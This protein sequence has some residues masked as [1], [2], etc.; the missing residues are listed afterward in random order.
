VSGAGV[1]GRALGSRYTL[2]ERIGQGA[3]GEVWRAWDR[4][5]ERE[6][7]AKLLWPQHAADPEILGR[8]VHERSV[9][10]GLD[11]P[12]VV[13]VHDFVVEGQDLAIVMD[14]VGGPSVGT[15]LRRQGTLPA[16]SAVP[17]AVA[18]LGALDSAH[19]RGVVHRD[20]KPDNVLLAHPGTPRAQDVRLADFGIAG[21]VQ[22]EGA[23]V[24]ELIGTPSYMPPELVSYGKFG[25]A[26]DVYAVGVALYEMLG[27]RTPFAGPGTNV[28]V[29]MRQVEAAPPRLPVDHALWQAV[30]RLLAKDPAQRPTAAASADLLDGLGPAALSGAALP[31]VPQP[32]EWARSTSVLPSKRAVERS[33]GGARSVDLPS[34]GPVP[35]PPAEDG[36]QDATSLRAGQPLARATPVDADVEPVDASGATMTRARRPEARA[37]PRRTAARRLRTR[38]R[39]LI[40]G[41]VALGLGGAGVAQWSSGVLETDS[42]GPDVEITTVAAHVNG[43]T[44]PTGL[45]VDL[46]AAFDATEQRTRL[47]VTLSASPNAPLRGDILLVTPGFGTDCAEVAEQDGLVRRVR[48]STDGLDL[49]C[50]YRLLDLDLAGGA[51]TTVDLV[52]DLEMVDDEGVVPDDYG[53]WLG[54]VQDATDAGLAGVPGTAFALQRVSGVL[55]EPSGVTL[56]GAATPVPYRVTASWAAGRTDGETELFTS[57]TSDGMEVELLRQL[58]GGAGLDGVTVTSCN[59]TQVIGIRVLAEQP[60]SSCHV[61]VAVGVLDSGESSF[62]IRMR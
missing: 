47:G 2:V 52:V 38:T 43:S 34:G 30:D 51:T 58:T 40:G 29:A 16:S 19:R 44:L 55:V 12:N 21:I 4:Q 54:S 18:V 49:A 28:T 33:L 46:D 3:S 17:L 62:G 15:L 37:A 31:V 14:L 45:R 10:L 53:E 48:A 36:A 57:D 25:P 9:L 32:E 26:S 39:V 50:G 7:A 5:A 59:A 8:F 41:A 56:D 27:G 13:A 35:G 24:T 1:S 61:R 11:H 22:D 23:P 60:E 42:T 20:V 6:V